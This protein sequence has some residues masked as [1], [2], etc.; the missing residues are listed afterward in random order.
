MRN[1]L[2]VTIALGLA[3]G[4]VANA[5]ADDTSWVVRIGVHVVDPTSSNGHLAGMKT[6][7]GS[8][9]RPTFSIE[10]M[11]TPSWGIDLLAAV[12][13][14]HDVSLDGQRAATTKQLPPTLGI[15]YHFMP[16]TR[17][18]PFVGVGVNYTRFFSTKGVGLLDGTHVKVDNSFGAAAH[19]G[20]DFNLAPNWLITADVRWIKISGDVHVN[21]TNVGTAKVD[22]LVYGV[23]VGYRF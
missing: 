16:D 7:I 13:F 12:P 14:R 5:H 22:P 3:L 4:C 1:F 9:T 10:Y 6:S 11:A 8:S 2:S 17:F 21:G 18:S 20:M 23:S 19:A 15:N